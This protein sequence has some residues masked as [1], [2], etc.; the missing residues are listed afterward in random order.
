MNRSKYLTAVIPQPHKKYPCN[1]AERI[2]C[3]T[4]ILRTWDWVDQ[5]PD[6]WGRP[7]MEFNYQKTIA[8]LGKRQLILRSEQPYLRCRKIEW[9]KVNGK[10]SMRTLLDDIEIFVYRLG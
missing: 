6:R 4:G 1:P 10:H 8:V 2:E 3:L 7:V 9:C 5:P